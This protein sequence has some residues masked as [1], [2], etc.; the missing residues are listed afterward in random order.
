MTKHDLSN[1]LS[2]FSLI[3]LLNYFIKF[4]RLLV[5]LQNIKELILKVYCLV[6]Q[7]CPTLCD[8]IDCSMPGSQSLLKHMFIES[9]KPFNHL[10][11]CNPLL[12]LPSIFPSIRVF[13]NELALH[14][15]LQSIGTSAS[16]AVL[17]MNIQGWFPL[18]L[19]GLICLLSKGLLQHHSSKASILQCSD[20]V[21]VSQSIHNY[22]KNHSFDY[23]DFVRNM[24]SLL[25]NMLSR[26]VIA[27]LPSSKH[28]FISWLQSPP[29][30]I[31]EPK[32]M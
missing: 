32:K 24:M 3:I 31:L 28:L 20:F 11:L 14:I 4:I 6:T 16:I 15:R 7:S 12:L 18:G 29:T 22:W 30:V 1:Y 13:S 8:P 10:I 27:F 17:P 26:F 9:M 25:F 21:V 23:M 19:I 2:L 5:C